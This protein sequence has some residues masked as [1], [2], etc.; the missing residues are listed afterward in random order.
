[1]G[2]V[3][4]YALNDEFKTILR[5]SKNGMVKP[6]TYVLAKTVLV[7]PIM[8][9]FAIFALGI[10]SFAIMDFPRRSFRQQHSALG[11]FDV[12]LRVNC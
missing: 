3:A 9:I 10:P 5:E 4:V 8:F 2:V 12:C 1:M 7:L 6:L 11:C